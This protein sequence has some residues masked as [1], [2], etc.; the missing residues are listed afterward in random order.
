MTRSITIVNNSNW[1]HEDYAVV[2]PRGVVYLKPGERTTFTPDNF[3]N[4]AVQEVT[5]EKP[6]P[7]HDRDEGVQLTP[8]IEVTMR[9]GRRDGPNVVREHDRHGTELRH[10]RVP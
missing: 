4:V 7:F 10:A 8:H 2:T 1:E 3:A 9:G 6:E 5:P